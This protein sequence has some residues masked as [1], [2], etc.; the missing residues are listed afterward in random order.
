MHT[1]Y[2]VIGST[3]KEVI[4][5]FVDCILLVS[6]SLS[7]HRS[8]LMCNAWPFDVLW[9]ICMLQLLS[10]CTGQLLPTVTILNFNQSDPAAASHPFGFD[11]VLLCAPRPRSDNKDPCQS[12]VVPTL[13]GPQWGGASGRWTNQSGRDNPTLHCHRSAPGR[14]RCWTR[15]NHPRNTPWT[16]TQT[17]LCLHIYKLQRTEVLPATR[18]GQT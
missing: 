10:I 11:P 7:E 17:Y 9:W 12:R 2:D 4:S 14:C 16:Y 8:G 6:P 13:T 1:K 3:D 18:P 15:W 5:N